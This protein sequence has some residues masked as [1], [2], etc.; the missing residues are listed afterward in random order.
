MSYHP[1]VSDI[2]AN[3]YQENRERFMEL[4]DYIQSQVTP[5]GPSREKSLALTSLQE[6]LMWTHAHV[7]CNWEQ[8]DA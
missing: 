8:P 7:A 5:H 6:A 3:V 4:F 1:V 2:Q